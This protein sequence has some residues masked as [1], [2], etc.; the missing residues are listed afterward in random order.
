[1]NVQNT[2]DRFERGAILGS[3]NISFTSVQL[4]QTHID[5]LGPH[6]KPLIDNKSSVVVI[7]GP[8]DQNNALVSN[9]LEQFTRRHLLIR[10]Q[11]VCRFPSEMRCRG[12]L[13]S[14]RRYQCVTIQISEH[15]S[16]CTLIKLRN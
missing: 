3:I 13:F 5:T 4:S 6:A 16:T 7:I 14:A 2:F 15:H 12:S 8:H 1:M 9:Y 10:F 11:T